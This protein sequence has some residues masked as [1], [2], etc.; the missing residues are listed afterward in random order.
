MAIAPY[1]LA[2]EATSKISS[3]ST[4][5]EENL[6]LSSASNTKDAS[7]K[8]SVDNAAIWKMVHCEIVKQGL[9]WTLPTAFFANKNTCNA[10]GANLGDQN[11]LNAQR[12]LVQDYIAQLNQKKMK[13]NSDMSFFEQTK[14]VVTFLE[15]ITNE[16]TSIAHIK[17][18]QL[19]TA[20]E[21][22]ESIKQLSENDIKI[23]QKM[24][25]FEHLKG[26]EIFK[27]EYYLTLTELLSKINQTNPENTLS[28]I[29]NTDFPLLYTLIQEYK[30]ITDN[31]AFL[32]NDNVDVYKIFQLKIGEKSNFSIPFT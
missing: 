4:Q 15:S 5:N 14:K 19:T 6:L 27:K 12:Q 24:Q 13:S 20:L 9:E 21:K 26:F 11:R 32:L 8:I 2:E 30:N 25:G 29:K 28:S 23:F 18:K 22:Q 1:A 3:H 16:T 10:I 31:E 17:N 7:P